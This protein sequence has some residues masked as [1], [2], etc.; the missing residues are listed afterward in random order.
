M[1]KLA[2]TVQIFVCGCCG[3]DG[4]QTGES[5]LLSKGQ[6]SVNLLQPQLQQLFLGVEGPGEGR[7]ELSGTVLWKLLSG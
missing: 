1:C 6:P 7:E 2:S 5:T 4:Q 3:Q